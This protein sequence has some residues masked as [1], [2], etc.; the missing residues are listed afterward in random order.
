MPK[1]ILFFLQPILKYQNNPFKTALIADVE[2]SVSQPSVS[3]MSR[4]P[5]HPSPSL[6]P[7]SRLD[8]GADAMVSTHS[9]SQ[10]KKQIEKKRRLEWSG[11]EFLDGKVVGGTVDVTKEVSEEARVVDGS[12]RFETGEGGGREGSC[13]SMERL[14]MKPTA[15]CVCA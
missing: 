8:D 15:T 6:Y 4:S 11:V 3:K 2:Y 13:E 9:K 10:M 5:L 1:I 12:L 14:L 7:Q